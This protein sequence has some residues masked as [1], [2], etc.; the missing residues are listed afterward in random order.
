MSGWGNET[1]QTY[2]LD[3]K[4]T[5]KLYIKGPPL[6]GS[7]RKLDEKVIIYDLLKITISGQIIDP[8]WGPIV[9]ASNKDKVNT[10]FEGDIVF[11]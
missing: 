2:E 1:W 3:I 10:H 8:V 5:D 4:L 11:Q 6:R 9:V 7:I